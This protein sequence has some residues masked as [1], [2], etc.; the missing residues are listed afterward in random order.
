MFFIVFPRGRLKIVI[1]VLVN[2]LCYVEISEN[3]FCSL[4]FTFYV[5][6][7][8][9]RPKFKKIRHA[10]LGKNVIKVFLKFHILI[11]NGK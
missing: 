3:D 5:I 6:K 9:Q 8:K 1:L 7:N 4:L 10:S 11:Q 2:C